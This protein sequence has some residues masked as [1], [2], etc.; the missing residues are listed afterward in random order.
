MILTSS[1]EALE[2]VLEEDPKLIQA[3]HWLLGVSSGQ[4]PVHNFTLFISQEKNPAKINV[5]VAV[6]TPLQ[7]DVETV[8]VA[9]DKKGFTVQGFADVIF[10][11]IHEK[12][13]I[14]M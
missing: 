4:I 10:P 13:I 5:F 3:D 7:G 8:K 11:H 6:F 9:A 2:K 14:P 12:D 1:I